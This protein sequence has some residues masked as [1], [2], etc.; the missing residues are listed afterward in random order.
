MEQSLQYKVAC[1]RVQ[2][3]HHHLCH[4]HLNLY[5]HSLHRNLF[6]KISSLSHNQINNLLLIVV[7]VLH[8]RLI[9]HKQI[10]HNN[11]LVISRHLKM[12]LV[13]IALIVEVHHHLNKRQMIPHLQHLHRALHRVRQQ[14]M[15]LLQHLRLHRSLRQQ[16]MQR[17]HLLHLQPQHKFL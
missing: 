1:R 3:C 12:V 17:P 4:K 11:L 9:N 15:H 2:C 7:Q 8:L 16:I 10:K 5:N 6:N 14:T 13:Q